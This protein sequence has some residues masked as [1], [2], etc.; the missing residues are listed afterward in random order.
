MKKSG[1][2]TGTSERG[3]RQRR[4][5]C[6]HM[7]SVF[8][9][10]FCPPPSLSCLCISRN[11]CIYTLDICPDP[12]K[13]DTRKRASRNAAA[14]PRLFVVRMVLHR[15]S[16]TV[17]W[18]LRRSAQHSA[19]PRKTHSDCAHCSHRACM[20]RFSSLQMGPGAV[21]QRS[22]HRTSRMLL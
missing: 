20:P 9:R 7:P 16:P 2:A 12:Q 5:A 1:N 15:T 10:R 22:A 4:R 6:R 3:P 8:E 21:H 13:F 14:P 17:L 19:L 11:I 18:P